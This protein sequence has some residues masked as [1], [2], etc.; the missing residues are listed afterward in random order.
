[1]D[2]LEED[3]TCS[4]C[5]SL[6]SDPRV[7]P[8]SHTFC[9]GCL[10]NVLQASLNYS[11][12][13][14][15]HQLKCP[16]CRSVVELSLTSVDTLPTNVPLQAIIE[17][18][19][20][21]SE[22][23]RP[24]CPE[25]FRQPLNM[26]CVQDRQLICG[27]CLT[28]G[29]HQ[30]HIID[31]LQ[32]AFNREKQTPSLLL[33]RL[34]EKRWTTMCELGEQLEQE[35]ARCESLLKNDQQEVKRFFHNVDAVLAKKRQVYLEV[36]DKAS[37][38]VSRAYDP[39]IH[40]VKEL[41]EEHLDLVSLASSVEEEDSPLV[42]LE[43]VHLFRERVDKF[44]NASLPSV[45]NLSVTPRAAEYLQQYW[46]VVTLGGLDEAP[47]PKV[48]CCTRCGSV[49]AEAHKTPSVGS[50]HDSR[51]KPITVLL[52][53]LLV[54][55]ASL[56]V[57]QFHSGLCSEFLPYFWAWLESTYMGMEAFVQRWCC[58]FSSM[59]EMFLQQMTTFLT[60]LTS[61]LDLSVLFTS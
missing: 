50:V 32:A 16:I 7:L 18:Y 59:G 37:V 3:L 48:C 1:M 57:S 6:F 58:H 9:K 25:H 39:L 56:G 47:V 26:Y 36:L 11:I 29:R 52:L 8:C 49:P 33:A 20:R 30:G 51:F 31:D 5:Y 14:P 34:S 24:L 13:R 10:D 43:K 46:P 44:T 38:E 60:N 45:L 17:K 42:F 15:L 27:L 2:T 41:Q 55:V 22:P 53:L 4:V 35:K 23:R 40:R 54:L 21:E 61:P 12:W 28:V 19:Q